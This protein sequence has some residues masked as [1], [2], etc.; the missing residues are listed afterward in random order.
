MEGG[1]NIDW[2]ISVVV[3]FWAYKSPKQ[4]HTRAGHEL[5]MPAL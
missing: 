1:C 5:K 4:C 3:S 2:V